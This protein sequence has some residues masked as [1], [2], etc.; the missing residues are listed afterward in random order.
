MDRIDG[1]QESD[2]GGGG[3]GAGELDRVDAGAGGPIGEG[4]GVVEDLETLRHRAILRKGE[5]INPA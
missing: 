1:G 4:A 5:S 3:E 2:L